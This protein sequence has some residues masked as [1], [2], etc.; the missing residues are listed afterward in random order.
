M[1]DRG[2]LEAALENGTPLI[3]NETTAVF[4][5][6]G[7]AGV[8]GVSG[9]MT[10]WAETIE[11]TRLDS[12]DLFWAR[13]H[14]PSA[15]RIEYLFVIDGQDPST[16]PSCPHKVL[17][18]L[19]AHSELAMPGYKHHPVFDA[20]RDGTPGGYERV[21]QHVVAAGGLGYEKEVQV[22]T[23][24][25]YE[26][27]TDRYPTVY[28]LDGRDYIEFAHTPAALDAL[29][30]N[31]AVTPL[32]AV[33]ISPPNRHLP[34]EP[35]RVTEYGLNP[36]YADWMA[37]ELVP[38]IDSE[39]RTVASPGTRMVA[40]D[41]Y[42]GVGSIY[43]PFQHPETFGLSYSQSGYLPLDGGAMIEAFSKSDRKTIRLY[44]DVGIYERKVGWGWL[45][46]DEIDFTSGN[47]KF[48]DVLERKAYDYVYREYPEGHTWGNWRAHMIDALVHFFP[49]N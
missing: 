36:V 18:G 44:I 13:V 6:K 7:D 34:D 3:E 41:S 28:I 27:G 24:P 17:N 22:Y 42:A 31:E 40:G 37:Q 25:G 4:V 26:K 48:S 2:S 33:F 19:G 12:T 46:D 47:R 14:F 1:L 16:D 15:A 11:L 35:N 9:D 38:F 21:K 20:V 29:I 10:N 5:F 43:V 49:N 30:S 45:P 23:P 32:V 39:Y 8:V